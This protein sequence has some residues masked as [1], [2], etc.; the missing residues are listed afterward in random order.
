MLGKVFGVMVLVSLGFGVLG[1]AGEAMAT[2]VLEGASAAIRLSLTLSGTM[3]LFC[4][5]MHVLEE[6]GAVRRL[7]HLLRRPLA[8]FFPDTAASGDGLE[9]ICANLAANLIGV[10]NAATPMALCALE[11]M[12]KRNPHPDTATGDMITLTVLNTCSVAVIPS[13]VLALRQQAGAGNP[14]EVL[15][16][17]WICSASCA[18]LALLITRGLRGGNF[19]EKKFPPGPPSKN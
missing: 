1:G 8:F 9:E 18:A 14:F 2:A 6:A 13:T 5:I 3:C 15:I 12:Q 7:A 10:G 19:F 4:G 17:I 11:K 16:P